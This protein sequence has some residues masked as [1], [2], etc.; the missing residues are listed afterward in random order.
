MV[1][2]QLVEPR[3]QKS[4]SSTNSFSPTR[5]IVELELFWALQR[6]GEQKLGLFF[7]TEAHTG[8]PCANSA[9]YPISLLGFCPPSL[10]G[11]SVG[12]GGTHFSRLPMAG[13]RFQKKGPPTPQ[14]RKKRKDLGKNRKE[15]EVKSNPTAV[16]RQQWVTC[17]GSFFAS[18]S[19][20]SSFL[21]K[22]RQFV[23]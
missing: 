14:K 7:G 1:H 16:C 17:I 13:G 21:I 9:K 20:Y 10:E 11:E 2:H 5:L 18:F 8:F 19:S 12:G 4:K 22:I 3:R 15:K 23:K 6:D